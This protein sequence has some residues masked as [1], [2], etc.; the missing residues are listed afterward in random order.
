MLR[1]L[2]NLFKNIKF[3]PTSQG[4]CKKRGRRQQKDGKASRGGS[5]RDGTM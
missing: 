3:H 5:E 4:K 1:K 2:G